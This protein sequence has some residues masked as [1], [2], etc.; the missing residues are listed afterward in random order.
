LAEAAS[1]EESEDVRMGLITLLVSPA[2]RATEGAGSSDAAQ[3]AVPPAVRSLGEEVMAHLG[4][5][6]PHAALT[7][8]VTRLRAGALAKRSKRRSERALEA[9]MDTGAA[10]RRRVNR[11][12]KKKASASA[13][14]EMYAAH[15]AKGTVAPEVMARR[16]AKQ[17]KKPRQTREDDMF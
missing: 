5:V 11:A 1:E 8:A 14:K 17:A 10:Q 9:V 12:A 4:N 15:K 7:A 13:R 3:Q 2:Y 6:L 16:M